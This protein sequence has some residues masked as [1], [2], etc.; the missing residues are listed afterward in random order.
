MVYCVDVSGAIESG[1]ELGDTHVVPVPL[2]WIQRA[3]LESECANP[4]SGGFVW[5]AGHGQLSMVVVPGA[6]KMDG[7]DL[8]C[9]AEG[10]AELNGGHDCCL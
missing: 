3:W 4:C 6:K 7:L 8:G 9:G 1:R 5:I 2:T 10:E